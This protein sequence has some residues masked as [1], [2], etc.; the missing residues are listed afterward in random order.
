MKKSFAILFAIGT[1]VACGP[2]PE[3]TL[4]VT[5]TG[6]D[7]GAMV[8]LMDFPTHPP[9]TTL[10]STVVVDGKFGFE[11]ADAYPSG[12]IIQFNVGDGKVMYP[13]VLEPGAISGTV[14]L[15]ETAVF[16]GTPTNDALN[17][18]RE[19]AAE[20]EARLNVSDLSRSDYNAVMREY[21]QYKA[22]V[23][24]DNENTV[25]AAYLLDM[26]SRSETSFDVVDSLLN[27]LSGTPANAFTDRLQEHRDRLAKVAVGRP[28]PDFTLD[29]PDGT[30]CSL[31]SLRGKLVLIDFWASWCG[32]CRAENPNVVAMYD[33]F[34]D[35]GF[36]I[37]G[38]SVD[39]D[40][41]AWL[42]AVDEDDLT[43]I[44]VHDTQDLS[45]DLYQVQFIPHTV[46]VDADGIIVAK[47]LHG[48]E[49]E[50][51]VAEM[52]TGEK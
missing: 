50:A 15:G 38:V 29:S 8:Y 51:K 32:P 18:T 14:K 24:Q 41:E 1:L 27:L 9:Q 12:R 37:L 45:N 10:D 44:Q 17:A 33:R 48:A 43:W 40:R 13:F 16:T 36:E 52:L 34:K 31:S 30:P 23:V 21:N 7:E 4:R 26:Q 47:D 25:L 28:A 49:L 46:L 3:A 11:F 35:K 19:G 6:V 2:K 5:V 39:D 22:K 20:L 42:K